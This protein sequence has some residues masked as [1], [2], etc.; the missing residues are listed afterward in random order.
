MYVH[1]PFFRIQTICSKRT[2]AAEVFNFID[3][4][5]STIVA[6]SWKSLRVFIR[7][8]RT[9]TFVDRTSREILQS[10]STHQKRKQGE[11][12]RNTPPHPPKK[13]EGEGVRVRKK[14]ELKKS[15]FIKQT[16]SSLPVHAIQGENTRHTNKKDEERGK[17]TTTSGC[18]HLR[19][20]QF[21]TRILTILFSLDHIKQDGVRHRQGREAQGILPT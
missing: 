6:S 15:A 9:K 12:G 19:S 8:T 14:A 7:Q 5:V 3:D 4:L 11:N 10:K 13:N 1:T 18:T 21:Q 20:N 17:N 16:S 2:V